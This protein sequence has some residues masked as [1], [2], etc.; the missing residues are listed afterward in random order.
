[1]R[2][3][4]VAYQRQAILS[5]YQFDGGGALSGGSRWSKAIAAAPA[6]AF[7]KMRPSPVT[8]LAATMCSANHLPRWV[9]RSS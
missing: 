1:V 8:R 5:L 9:P 7:P 3:F 2:S 6:K 4:N